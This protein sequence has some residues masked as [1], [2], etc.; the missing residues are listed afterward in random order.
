MLACFPYFSSYMGFGRAFLTVAVIE[1]PMAK[2][3]CSVALSHVTC[4]R[5]A[6]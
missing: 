5:L 4:L 3:R 1:P 6:E 2:V